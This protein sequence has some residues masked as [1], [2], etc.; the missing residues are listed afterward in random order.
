MTCQRVRKSLK[1]RNLWSILLERLGESRGCD[2]SLVKKVGKR[3]SKDLNTWHTSAGGDQIQIPPC[4]TGEQ[5]RDYVLRSMEKRSCNSA[6][7]GQNSGCLQ[8]Q[9]KEACMGA[10]RPV[11]PWN[12]VHL[13]PDCV[14]IAK[15]AFC[16]SFL[17]NYEPG[18]SQWTFSH[19]DVIHVVHMFEPTSLSKFIL[20]GEPEDSLFLIPNEIRPLLQT[21]KAPSWIKGFKTELEHL[22]A[23]KML[24]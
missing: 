10:K 11:L 9:K 15:L 14:H 4:S 12:F 22:R 5:L 2:R 24:K 8:T 1:C 20:M 23:L 19:L 7:N 3:R 17:K 18:G 6:F 13:D 16:H 21:H